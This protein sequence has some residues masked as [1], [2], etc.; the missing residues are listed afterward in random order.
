VQN[1]RTLSP[2]QIHLN[3]EYRTAKS[4]GHG[5]VL[6]GRHQRAAQ[7]KAKKNWKRCDEACTMGL[8]SSAQNAFVVWAWQANNIFYAARIL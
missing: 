7:E 4:C 3:S 1:R 6:L 2:E 5:R 8:A